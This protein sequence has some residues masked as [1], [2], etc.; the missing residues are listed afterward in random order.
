MGFKVVV[1]EGKPFEIG[2]NHEGEVLDYL[3]KLKKGFE[4]SEDNPHTDIFIY[5]GV[6]N[7]V[8]DYFFDKLGV[9][10]E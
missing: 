8:S 3:K 10:N 2:F 4:D 7:D 1:D 9:E 6:S 5:D